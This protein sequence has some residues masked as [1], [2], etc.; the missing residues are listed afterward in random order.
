MNTPEITVLLTVFN[1]MP[2]LPE[3]VESILAQT[4]KDFTFLILNNGS[5]DSSGE[6]L[7]SLSDPRLC[8]VH[9]QETLPR[10]EVLNKALGMV[11]TPLTAVIDAD[12]LA[13]PDRLDLQAALLARRPEVAFVGCDVRYVSPE[14][15]LLGED[16][17]PSDHESLLA[18]MPL[19][20][21]FAHA[22]CMYRTEAARAVGGYPLEYPYAQD[23]GLWL[24]LFRAGNK[25][26]S[27]PT[28]LAGIRV[29]PGQQTRSQ[30]LIKARAEDDA[31]L[32]AAMLDI[33]N[34]PKAS[35]QAARLRRAAALYRLGRFGEAFGE[36]RSAVME[37]PLLLPVN[38]ILWERL[39]R[40]ARRLWKRI[41]K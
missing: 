23:Q 5:K 3:A 38:P 37:A 39:Q 33:P 11:Q 12:D 34:L 17:F 2:Y 29:H 16:R 10:T 4:R 7:K 26:A 25:A 14:G 28:F 6:Y 19:F 21:Q 40:A 15:A 22:G 30:K 32:A 41:R 24:A 20:N 35:R 13:E 31:R 9:L 36:V 27:I 1:G 18:R 8:V